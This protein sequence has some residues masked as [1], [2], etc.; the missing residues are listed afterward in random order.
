M[1]PSRRALK[2]GPPAVRVRRLEGGG[3]G[4]R[5]RDRHPVALFPRNCSNQ[6]TTGTS[7]QQRPEPRSCES[8]GSTC[9]AGRNTSQPSPR[10][11]R[12][13]PMPRPIDSPP[14]PRNRPPAGPSPGQSRRAVRRTGQFRHRPTFRA[15]KCISDF[16]QLLNEALNVPPTGLRLRQ[17]IRDARRTTGVLVTQVD[18]CSNLTRN[19]GTVLPVHNLGYHP[20]PAQICNAG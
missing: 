6:I 17:A 18:L 13:L 20:H 8:D 10:L 11:E 9:L 1:C 19:A 12:C 4:R 16:F 15:A 7:P 2:P 3:A 5:T 14:P